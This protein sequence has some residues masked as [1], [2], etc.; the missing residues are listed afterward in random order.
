VGQDEQPLSLV[1][2]P[3]FRRAEYSERAA[4]TNSLKVE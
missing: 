2:R 3:D 4:I 1:R